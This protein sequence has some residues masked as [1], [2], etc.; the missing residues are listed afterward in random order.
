MTYPPARLRC[1]QQRV[2]PGVHSDFVR[3]QMREGSV[4]LATE[5][6]GCPLP[7]E[8]IC[9]EDCFLWLIFS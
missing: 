7:N 3:G 5:K 6:L 2:S 9:Y 8:Q 4:T 1:L